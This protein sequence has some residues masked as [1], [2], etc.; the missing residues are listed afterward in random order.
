MKDDALYLEVDED[1]TSAIDKLSKTASSTVQIVV[2]KRSTMLQSIINLKLLK[3]AAEGSGRKIV[4]VTGD[5]VATDLASRVGLAVAPSLG[6]EAVMREAKMPAELQNIEEVIEADDPPPPT[7]KPTPPPK[8]AKKPLLKRLAVADGPPAP[9]PAPVASADAAEAGEATPA[10]V[11]PAAKATGGRA[12]K[13]PNFGRLQK[14]VM[15]VGFAAFLI[16]GYLAAMYFVTGAKVTLYANANRVSID[17]TFSVDP[18]LK[19][20]DKDKAVLAGQQV[21][22]T[23]DLS[24]PITPTGKKDVGTKASGTVVVSNEYDTSPHTL[25]AGTRFQ[26]PDGKIFKSKADSSVPG[27]T[28]GLSGGQIVLNP[29][30]SPAIP[31]E[32]EAAGDT[33]NEAAAKYTIP[34]YAGAMQQK[35]TAQASQMSG[36]TSKTVTVVSQ[37]DV[38][39]AKSALLDKSKDANLKELSGKAPS[40][41]MLLEPSQ[42]ITTSQVESSPEV[43]AEA[44]SATLT[45]KV[46]YSSLAV[47]KSE[48]EELIA[49]QE[50][51][52]VGD[53]SQIY[54]N[55]LDAAQ[56]TIAGKEDGG[57]FSFHLTTEAYSGAKLD[58]AAIADKL[59]GERYGDAVKTASGLAGV[60]RAEISITP[61]WVSKLP[62]RPDKIHINIQ[63]SSK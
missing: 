35:I 6:A 60:S 59:K 51:K 22:I 5:R 7:P 40:G 14:R 10:A 36:G 32:A 44:T 26:A 28:I 3:K 37:A 58:K 62:S 56:L 49:E 43:D 27:A 63:V 15:W 38:E 61:A 19:D 33:Y 46:S 25:V 30:K 50:Q 47:K 18:E 54:Q 8:S 48:F 29:G 1:I 39:A 4:L 24:G 52:Q 42:S 11:V 31:V 17:T 23:K 9:A 57:R 2:P 55:G 12:V 53:A 13:V 21:S 34:G 16:V 41:Y 20:T 45:M